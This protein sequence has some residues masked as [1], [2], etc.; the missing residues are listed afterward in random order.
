MSLLINTLQ[1]NNESTQRGR[2]MSVPCAVL[3]RVCTL[4]G[5]RMMKIGPGVWLIGGALV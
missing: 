3:A 5:L 4:V 1:V 2:R